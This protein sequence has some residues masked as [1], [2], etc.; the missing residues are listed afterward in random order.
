MRLSS[1]TVTASESMS[2]STVWPL[3][4]ANSAPSRSTL[5]TVTRTVP[6]PGCFSRNSAST[7]GTAGSSGS[8]SGSGCSSRG[9]FA[10]G[11]PPVG[12]GCGGSDDE[13]AGGNPI[14][15]GRGGGSPCGGGAGG[16]PCG[17]GPGGSPCGGGLAPPPE[18]GGRVGGGRGTAAPATAA[19]SEPSVGGGGIGGRIPMCGGGG[20]PGGGIIGGGCI[21][22]AAWMAAICAESEPLVAAGAGAAGVVVPWSIGGIPT[23]APAEVEVSISVETARLSSSAVLPKMSGRFF[24]SEKTLR[25]ISSSLA[26]VE[27][28]I[29][30]SMA[31]FCSFHFGSR[32]EMRMCSAICA[33]G[34]SSPV[35][36]ET[37]ISLEG[38][39]AGAAPGRT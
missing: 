16:S 31:S 35:I 19:P 6:A 18:G 29:F 28:L 8:G 10:S 5:G 38:A 22:F 7:N 24:A 36:G 33:T 9:R 14:G 23:V 2:S 4:L 1:A 25:K 20:K 26:L 21:P 11:S 30:A 12:G 27:S 17:G 15:G 32:R 3:S 39:A 34:T 13:G 37:T